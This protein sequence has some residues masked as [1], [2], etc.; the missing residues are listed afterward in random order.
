M[1][2]V[3]GNFWVTDFGLARLQSDAGLTMTGDLLGTLRYM[4]PEQALAQR[5]TIDHRTDI[6][7]LGATLY[8]LL[9]LHPVFEG[10]DRQALLRQ[11]AFNDP[12]PLPRRNSSV[13]KEL[14]TIVL[15]A[16]AKDSS[17]RYASA[18]D[19]ADD[20]RRYLENKPIRARRPTVLERAVKWSRRHRGLVASAAALLLLTVVRLV[21]GIVLLSREQKQT[22]LNLQLARANEARADQSTAEARAVVAFLVDD[23]L[24]AAAPSRTGGKQITVLEALASAD[25]S[26]E[27][28]F[29]QE[30]LVE[31]AVRQAL[32]QA[33]SELGEYDKAETHAERALAL[34]EDHQGPEH[35]ATLRAMFTLA[36]NAYSTSRPEKIQRSEALLGQMLDICRRT[37]GD[38]DELTLSAMDGLACIYFGLNT[39]EEALNCLALDFDSTLRTNN[40]DGLRF[41]EH[42]LEVRRRKNGASHPKTLAA[43]NNLALARWRVGKLRE[44]EPLLREVVETGDKGDSPDM[45]NGMVNYTALMNELGRI[46]EA[47]DWAAHSM[48]AHLRVLRFKHPKTQ[49]AILLAG[50]IMTE[51]FQGKEAF[52]IIDGAWEE[53]RREFG[54]DDPRTLEFLSLRIR[55]LCYLGELAKAR[56]SAEELLPARTRSLAQGHPGVLSTL[57]TLAL[58]RRNQGATSEAAALFERLRVAGGQTLDAPRAQRLDPART[59]RIQ[60]LQAFAEVAGRNLRRPERS[61]AAPGTPGGPPRIDAPFQTV[62]PIADGRIEPGEYGDGDGFAYDFTTGKNPGRSFVFVE[63]TPATKDPS[64]LSVRMHA[65][66]TSDAL[67]LAFRVR[68]QYLR[69]D[70]ALARLPWLNDAVEVFLDGD[71]VANESQMFFP[72]NN[73]GFH[74]VAD[75]LGNR[76][77]DCPEVRNTRWKVGTGRTEDGYIIEFEIPLDLID[78]QDGPGFQAAKTGSELRMNVAIDDYDQPDGNQ[79]FYGILWSEDPLWSPTFGGEDFWPVALRLMPAAATVR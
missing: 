24:G 26:I 62:S 50:K 44:V 57:L 39:Y 71:R 17:A 8:E 16:L 72:G 40:Q 9:T 60:R 69:T 63:S 28:K 11:I 46:G 48:E 49:L 6:Y 47:A 37:R 64:D 74:L 4:S 79:Q 13:P 67:Y 25:R 36:W 75:V 58:I 70:S 15:K 61:D 33:Y 41:L 59:L 53:A 2:D 7:S 3:Q 30:P 35:E 14:E 18:Q 31:A 52:R 43:M 20:L 65:A 51:N 73:E 34:R 10:E 5:V 76:F 55:P 38:E 23:M 22:F 27:G 66:H 32:A 42:I 29:A 1:V 12:V 78:T 77:G 56:E 19:L 54:P 68:D 21:I 45:L